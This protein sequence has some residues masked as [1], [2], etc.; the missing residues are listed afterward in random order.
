MKKRWLPVFAVTFVTSILLPG[1]GQSHNWGGGVNSAGHAGYDYGTVHLTCDDRV[2]VLLAVDGRPVGGVPAPKPLDGRAGGGFIA[3]NTRPGGYH[4]VG[5]PPPR[6]VVWSSTTCDGK[7][8]SVTV[9]GQEFDLSQGGLFL[10]SLMD[11]QA[12]VE[13]LAADLSQLDGSAANATGLKLWHRFADLG[14]TEPRFETFWRR[15]A[16]LEGP[17]DRKSVV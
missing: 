13:Q 14:R 12:K 8:G 11:N 7:T 4:H 3:P 9:D 6:E 1:C 15:A 2:Y 10:I 5:D 16:C 17:R